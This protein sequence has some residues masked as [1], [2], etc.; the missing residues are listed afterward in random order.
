MHAFPFRA[1]MPLPARGTAPHP[2]TS[3]LTQRN[4]VRR[5]AGLAL[6]PVALAGLTLLGGCS[7]LDNFLGGQ[8]VDYR[9]EAAKTPA[10]EVPPDLTQLARDG[11]Y[12][13]QGGGVVSASGVAAQSTAGPSAAADPSVALSTIGAMR[14]ERQG[15]QRWL[16][17]PMTPEQLWPQLQAFWQERGFAL[18]VQD[19]GAGIMETDWAENR[20]KLPQDFVRRTI[21]RILENL[22]DTG[23]R[24]KF[25]TRVERTAN[26]AE[27]YISHRAV[28]EIFAERQTDRTVWKVAPNDP[29]LEAEFLARLMIKLGAK[30]DA[31]KTAVAAAPKPAPTAPGVAATP[32]SPTAISIDLAEGFDRAWRRVGL[33][34][35]RTG[36]TVEDRDRSSGLYFVR[37]VANAGAPGEEPGFFSRL[38]GSKDAQAPTRYRVVVKAS[39]DARTTVSV[40]NSQ[41]A[42][43]TGDAAKRIISLIS[44]DLR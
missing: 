14:I 9:S 11:R 18:A 6:A 32:S 39:G 41:G 8:R 2:E 4:L 1:V 10:L 22:Y 12:R 7:A 5:S 29:Q 38:F 24:D 26:G 30:E 21:G 37:Y 35:D 33:A 16:V 43:E 31:A 36:F 28:Q 27:V 42:P 17:V 20:A 34:L 15:N 19:A 3:T 40:Q 13:P 25:R 44:S 23:E